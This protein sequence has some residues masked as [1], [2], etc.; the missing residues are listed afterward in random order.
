[1][2]LSIQRLDDF[3]EAQEITDEWQILAITCLIWVCECSSND[4]AKFANVAHV[5]ATHIGIKRK[6]PAHG[7]VCLLLRSEK[8]HKILVVARRDDECMMREPRFLHDPINLGLAGKVGNVE[9]AA[10]DRF[11][12]RQRG[13]DKV[14]DTGILGSAYR[15]RCL[16]E[17]VGTCFPEIGDQKDAMC[18]FKCSFKGF[19]SV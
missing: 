15:S 12:I 11:D 5:K 9:P 6:S 4:V 1:M 13:P 18:L 7:S 2:S 8:A 14:F 17:F 3:V 16:I 10:A 19:R